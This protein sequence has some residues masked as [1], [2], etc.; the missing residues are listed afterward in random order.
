MNGGPEKIER[1]KPVSYSKLF[2]IVLLLFILVHSI[3]RDV[4]LEK[5]YTGDLRNR[6][7][8]AR[9]Q[10]DG[11]LPYFYYWQ[12]K[13]GTRYFD[14]NNSN[15][16]SATVSPI[17]AS[18]FFHQLLY[19]I[20]DLDQRTLS[21]IW[22]VIQY[23][24]LFAM[25]WLACRMT[26]EAN[27][28]WL[29]CN[30]GVLFTMTE[31]WKSN[32]ENGQI[33][34]FYTFLTLC[35]I[36]CI[37]N[38]KRVWSMV[39]ALIMA[40]WILNRPIGIIAM[41]PILLLYKQQ[42]LFLFTAMTSLLL[43]V[44][45]VLSSPFE[46]TLWLNYMEGIRMQ[47]KFHQEAD[48]K[49]SLAPRLLPENRQLEGIDFNVV[50]QNMMEHPIT[51]YS[52]NGNFFVLYRTLTHHKISL[53]WLNFTLLFTIVALMGFYYYAYKKN[54]GSPLQVL[55]F[56]FTL[57]MIIEIFS[58]VYRHQ[59]N[60]VQWFPLVLAALGIPMKWKNPGLLLLALGLLLNIV[61]VGWIPMRH[62]LGE[63]AWLAALLYLSCLYANDQYAEPRPS[64]D[65]VY[66]IPAS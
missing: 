63:L 34:L 27:I 41:L 9:L 59:Y 44:I 28:R 62:T 12:A 46:K 47:V 7:V 60:T 65:G 31:A 57:Y 24:L 2:N 38:K 8:G 20:C 13:D 54:K 4:Y 43:Y 55:I 51:V 36:S 21:E 15:Q 25:I 22:F 49:A 39:A 50:D 64:P 29:I 26:H 33:Y 66:T 14:P 45:F 18:P 53:G 30:T 58:P 40:V 61:N 32:I 48:P 37:L 42:R 23:L 19:P 1:L 35:I 3:I 10:K 6:I 16:S 11:R 56:A 5:Q 52:E 17:T